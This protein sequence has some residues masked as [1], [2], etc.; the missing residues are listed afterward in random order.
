[1]RDP[2]PMPE[3]MLGR[4]PHLTCEGEVDGFKKHLI[5]TDR[6]TEELRAALVV[7]RLELVRGK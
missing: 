6:L 1:M 4:I 7:R 5:E 3:D 2:R